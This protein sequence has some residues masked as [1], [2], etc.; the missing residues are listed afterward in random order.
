MPGKSNAVG[1]KDRSSTDARNTPAN[2][3]IVLLELLRASITLHNL[4]VRLVCIATGLLYINY[5]QRKD[6]GEK[7]GRA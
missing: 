4:S 6:S 7:E 5:R 2:E 1:R 3:M